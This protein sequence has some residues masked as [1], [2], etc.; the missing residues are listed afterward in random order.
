MTTAEEDVRVSGKTAEQE[1]REAI[2]AT[3]D[4]LPHPELP[5]ERNRSFRFPGFSRMRTEWYGEDG[6]TMRMVHSRVEDVI[7]AAFNDLFAIR[8]ELY[9]VVRAPELDGDGQPRLDR[10]G[11]IV[12]RVDANGNYDEDWKR[13]GRDQQAR[14]LFLITTR[15]FEWE[16]RMDRMWAEAMM[17]KTQWEEAFST[18]WQSTEGNRP[19]EGDKTAQGR[20]T[21]QEERYFAIYLTYLSR[22]AESLVRG[23]E[24][25]A[26]R[27]K[28]VHTA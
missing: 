19:T 28:D 26:Q 9:D 10:H 1:I 8:Q 6:I 2:V 16:E 17:G 13:L 5:E 21:S 18:G 27:I 24:R 23:M 12:W 25:L 22:R 20:L 3:A 15:I 4:E 11:W 14:F 7:D